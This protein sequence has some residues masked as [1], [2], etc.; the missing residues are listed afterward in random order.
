MGGAVTRLS[1]GNLPVGLSDEPAADQS[2]PIRMSHGDLFVMVSDGVCDGSDD[3]WLR[4]LLHDRAGDT[5]KELAAKI[6]VS[7]T[8]RGVSDDLTAMVVRLERRP[9]S[10]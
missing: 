9:A 8:E 6:V 4:H 7:A 5:P 2:V 1:G 10:S 3:D